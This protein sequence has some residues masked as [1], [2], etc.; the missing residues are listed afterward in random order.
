MYVIIRKFIYVPF[1]LL[2]ELICNLFTPSYSISFIAIYYYYLDNWV[3]LELFDKAVLHSLGAIKI[4]KDDSVL[5]P[6]I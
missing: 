4:F 5:N 2:T 1:C 3:K 6:M